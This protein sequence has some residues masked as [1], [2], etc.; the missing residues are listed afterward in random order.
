MEVVCYLSEYSSPIDTVYS[1]EMISCVK[2]FVRED[3]FY[4]VLHNSLAISLVSLGI[5]RSYLTVIKSS[6]YSEIVNIFVKNG[7]HL[8]FLNG[9]YS[10]IAMQN[11]YIDMFLSSQSIYSSTARPSAHNIQP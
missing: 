6:V 1:S 9:R 7:S 5:I 10:L 2:S 3:F 11:I 4:Y 8:S